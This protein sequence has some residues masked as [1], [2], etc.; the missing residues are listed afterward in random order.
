MKP[1]T[2]YFSISLILISISLISILI[3]NYPRKSEGFIVDESIPED[4]VS[5]VP[6]SSSTSSLKC[7][8]KNIIIVYGSP[9]SLANS[10]DF[11][12]FLGP[13]TD[14][15]DAVEFKKTLDSRRGRV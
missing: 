5:I 14:V 11:C 9:N 10:N 13:S 12:F 15:N 1:M 4:R 7:N 3:L 6:W 2:L 8:R